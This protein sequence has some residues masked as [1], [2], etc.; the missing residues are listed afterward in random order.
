[1]S[2]RKLTKRVGFGS[3][4]P[5]FQ[6]PVVH[7]CLDPQGLQVDKPL[8]CDP[9]LYHP[10]SIQEVYK[11]LHVTKKD[12]WRYKVELT[13]W[14]QNLGYK[15]QK[16]LERRRWFAT[17]LGPAWTFV[18]EPTKC[19]AACKNVGFG[20]VSRFKPSRNAVPGPGTYFREQYKAPYGPH[21]TRPTFDREP[22]CRFLD[23]NIRSL[24][25]N[26]Y[27]IV[28]K[29]DIE[30]KPMKG[31]STRGPYDLFTGKRDGSTIRNHFGRSQIVY[32]KS[33]PLKFP[34]CL[35]SLKKKHTGEWNKT[36]RDHPPRNRVALADLAMI[37]RRPSDPSPVTY[38]QHQEIEYPQLKHGFN[39]SYDQPPGYVKM[40]VWPG[41]GRYTLAKKKAVPGKGHRHVFI[42]KVQRTIGAVIPAPMNTF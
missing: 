18:P 39:S 35:E 31:F 25:P 2:D 24:A 6:K 7:P 4:V 33:W 26:R 29:E 42:S 41:V 11:K 37:P 21:S 19:E 8:G 10:Q 27:N 16:I 3:S 32:S 13:D 5:R 38:F 34:G 15:N 17:L 23:S 30:H 1:M 12:P 28:D 20:R 14:C 40:R 9:A 36:G 22:P